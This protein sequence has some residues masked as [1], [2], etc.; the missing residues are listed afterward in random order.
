MYMSWGTDFGMS[1]E[2]PPIR[3]GI[4]IT[5]VIVIAIGLIF[6]ALGAVQREE[7]GK[8][9]TKTTEE[10]WF[11]DEREVT[12]MDKLAEKNQKNFNGIALIM[13]GVFICI[14]GGVGIASKSSSRSN[15]GYNSPIYTRVEDRPKSTGTIPKSSEPPGKIRINCPSCKF[16]ETEDATFCSKC[17][18][19][20]Y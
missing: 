13:F 17:G 9:D 15:I 1:T 8:I 11:G 12:D 10:V 6:I 5:G 14:A 7:A 3:K 16:L 4:V 20:L 2:K 18:S 19:K